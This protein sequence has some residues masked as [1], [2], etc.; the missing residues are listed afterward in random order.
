MNENL[1]LSYSS[2]I[3]R[4]LLD[5]KPD[6]NAAHAGLVFDR[7]LKIWKGVPVS[8]DRKRERYRPLYDFAEAFN[9]RGESP[10]FQM[11]LEDIETRMKRISKRFSVVQGIYAVH[12]RL[13]CGLGN[14]HP[15]ENGFTFDPV[16]GV[17]VLTGSSIKGLCRATAKME[18]MEENET[19]RLFGHEESQMEQTAST[20]ELCFYDAYPLRWPRIG[21]DIVNCHHPGY[22]VD[23]A[24][25]ALPL[26]TESPNP[27]FFCCVEKGSQFVFRISS[28]NKSPQ[29][30]DQD[31]PKA[32]EILKT[33]LTH[34]GIGSKTSVGYGVFESPSR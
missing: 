20:G 6:P 11:L 29:T 27:V 16:V 21:V 8:P 9:K 33:G 2:E 28:R 13:A 18:G 25:K 3:I 23:P 4:D 26:E 24:R 22:Y 34:F 19:R 1:L 12:W 30:A 7:F 10:R 15:T 5:D 31:L 14:D 32:L 17:P